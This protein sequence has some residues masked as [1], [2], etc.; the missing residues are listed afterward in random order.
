MVY[1]MHVGFPS[2]LEGYYDTSWITNSEDYTSTTGWVFLLSGGA[3][4]WAFKKQTCITGSIMEAKFV[5]LVATDPSLFGWPMMMYGRLQS[6]GGSILWNGINTGVRIS[7]STKSEWWFEGVSHLHIGLFERLLK[8][9]E[10][11][12]TSPEKSIGAIMYY[13]GKHLHSLGRWQNGQIAKTRSTTSST[14]KGDIVDQKDFCTWV[15]Y[16]VLVI[17]V[18]MLERSIG[19]QLEF[20][21]L[22]GLV[23]PTYSNSDTLHNTDC[24]ERT[25]NYF[26][27]SEQNLK[28]L[29]SSMPLRNVCKLVNS[30][31]AKIASD[32]NFKHENMHLLAKALLGSSRSVNDGLYRALDIYFEV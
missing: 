20:A 9:M 1:H 16:C 12:G 11:N 31:M 6:P 13:S 17:N 23:I 24:V 27:A 22:E 28:A 21:T 29:P 8:T 3:I 32:V 26:L 10:A 2:V 15:Y 5:A 30:Y 18:E 14:T 25:V 19:M 4:S 7:E